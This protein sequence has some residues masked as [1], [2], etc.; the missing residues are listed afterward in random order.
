[1]RVEVVVEA[2]GPGVHELAQPFRTRP[3]ELLHLGRID[4]QPHAQVAPDLLLALRFGETPHGVEVVHLDPVEV[5]LRLR[6]DHAEHGVGVGSPPN[7][8]D[9]PLVAR[10]GDVVGAG[11]PAGLVQAGG[12]ARGEREG[13]NDGELL[14]EG[15]I[16][17]W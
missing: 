16:P 7:V 2:V 8:G 10:D 12:S 9:P 6:V 11:L 14:H 13:E 3:V 17:S 15:H 1:M 5:V 4:E